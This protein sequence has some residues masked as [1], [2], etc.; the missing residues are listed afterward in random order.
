[1]RNWVVAIAAAMI[2]MLA[3]W[4]EATPLAGA[5]GQLPAIN[6]SPIEKVDCI[7]PGG[8]CPWGRHRVCGPGFCWCAPCGG[9]WRFW[10]N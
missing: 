1:M 4:A 2:M 6:Y 7:G 8:E 5:A 3:G 10:R 9:L